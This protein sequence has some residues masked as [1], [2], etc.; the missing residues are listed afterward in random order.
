MVPTDTVDVLVVGGGP[1][2]LTAALELRRRGIDCRVVDRLPE[3]LPYAKAVGIQPRTLEIWD[4]M[5]LVRA[6]LEAAV[7]MLGQ[8]TYV[9]GVERP[10]IELVLPPEVP[11]GFAALPQY[12][13]ER[14]LDEFLARF[15]TRIER[16]TE[17]VG[18]EQDID[19]VTSSLVTASGAQQEVRSRY[20]V[21]CDG[22]HSAVRKGLGLAFE[23][24]AFPEEYMLGDVE[25]DWDLPRGYGV[26]AVRLGADGA[27]DD[28]LVCIPLPGHGRY[29]VSTVVPP[30]LRI[31]GRT[32]DG[33]GD[34]DGVAH[35]L[36]SGAGPSIAHIQAALDRLSPRPAT[37]SALRW[38]SVFRISHRIVDRYAD[39]RVFVAGDAAHIHPPTGAQGMN[40]GIQDAYNLAWKLALAIEGGAAPAL[41]ASYDA[42]RRPVGV[43][44]VGRTVRHAAEGV[45]ADPDD[46]GT[47]ILREAQLLVGYRGSPLAGPPDAG[48]G[49]GPRPGDRAPDCGGLGGHIAA[50]PLRLYDLLRDR[51]HVL[52]LYGD[53][54][55]SGADDF[56]ALAATAREV[57]RGRVGV[58]VLLPEDAPADAGGAT[59]L[60]LYRDRRGEFARLYAAC[61]RTAF[62]VRPDGYLSARLQPPTAGE[63]ASRLARVFQA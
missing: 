59:T 32:G 27:V 41:L 37:A 25:V 53:G 28:V 26:R 57:S 38:S 42:E 35:G 2:G 6:A 61:G 13:T 48:E 11:Y 23:G 21:G 9:N 47:V 60:P 20:L 54:D 63:L 29:R 36:E 5:G 43:E 40:T 34:G 51:D 7:P 46:P 24:G 17:L 31:S 45:Q 33:G 55:G 56:P 58:C 16:G 15:G 14:I 49:S 1:V 4:R 3:R 30:E 10:P 18:F 62:L 22:A 44:V 52:L 12:E 19:G 50:Y 8:L 39:G